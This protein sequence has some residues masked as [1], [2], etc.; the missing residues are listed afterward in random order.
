MGRGSGSG[1]VGG[2][3]STAVVAALFECTKKTLTSLTL[4]CKILRLREMCDYKSIQ[5]ERLFLI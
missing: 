1:G 2:S 3:G 4:Y 5:Q